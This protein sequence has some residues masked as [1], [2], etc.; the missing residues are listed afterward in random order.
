MQCR[1]AISVFEQSAALNQ[2]R[3]P[4]LLRAADYSR[5]PIA[6]R[7]FSLHLLTVLWQNVKPVTKSDNNIKSIAAGRFRQYKEIKEYV[8]TRYDENTATYCHHHGW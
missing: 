4:T 1:I 7:H 8:R 2:V 3:I 6:I 5:T